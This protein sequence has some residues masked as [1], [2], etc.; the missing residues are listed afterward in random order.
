[1]GSDGAPSAK[2]RPRALRATRTGGFRNQ[3][4]LW[5]QASTQ[6]SNPAWPCARGGSPPRQGPMGQATG[7]HGPKGLTASGPQPTARPPLPPRGHPRALAMAL[8][9][10]GPAQPPT[11]SR[12][13]SQELRDSG[14][15]E[16]F[17]ITSS[18]PHT[19][20]PSSLLSAAPGPCRTQS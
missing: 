3:H 6:A 7:F 5:V 18:S 4:E 20:F 15:P 9:S 19:C 12:G 11:R 8:T 17:P 10:K 13:S 2:R 16:A 14:P 1:M